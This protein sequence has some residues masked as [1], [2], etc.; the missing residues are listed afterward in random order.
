[1]ETTRTLSHDVGVRPA[2][3][4]LGVPRASFY[5]WRRGP[6]PAADAR[7]GRSPRALSAAERQHVKET[8][9]SE[10]FVDQAPREVY[11][12]LLDEGQ[13]LCSVRTM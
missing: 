9:Y 4:A 8:L 10:R 7:H 5:R 1:M 12:A 3:Q 2:C 13:Y 11:A 6:Q